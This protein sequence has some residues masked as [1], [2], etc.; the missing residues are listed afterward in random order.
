MAQDS[1][2]DISHIQRVVKQA[3]CLAIKEDADIKIVSTAAWL[4][5]LVNYAKDDPNRAQASFHSASEAEPLLKELGFAAPEVSA[6]QHAIVTHSFSAQVTPRTL[7]AKIVQDADRLDALGAIG[8]ARCMMVGGRLNR[9]LYELID[10]FCQEREPNDL[11]YTIDHFY[12]K[13]LNLESTFQTLSGRQEAQRR[14]QFMRSFL[15]QLALEIR[16]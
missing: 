1:A 4:H 8:V 6:I 7:E 15:D 13:L 5:D 11:L 12:K 14:S 2:H 10:P 9:S 16:D 3:K